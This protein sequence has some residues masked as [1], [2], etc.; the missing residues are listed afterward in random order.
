MSD[1]LDICDVYAY[2]DCMR[3][4]IS[5][6]DFMDFTERFK[7]AGLSGRLRGRNHPDY[8]ELR[9][10][11]LWGEMVSGGKDRVKTTG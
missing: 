9:R 5:S 1:Y 2:Y 7:D 3:D 6:G 4:T 11:T 8:R 10:L